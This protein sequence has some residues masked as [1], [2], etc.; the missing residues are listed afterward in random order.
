M[1]KD[2]D[3]VSTD[4]TGEPKTS[5][6]NAN[7]HASEE[8]APVATG[9]PNQTNTNEEKNQNTAILKTKPDILS[10]FDQS[11]VCSGLHSTFNSDSERTNPRQTDLVA[12]DRP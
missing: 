7:N 10:R 5:G 6:R 12:N 4:R 9:N 8:I 2:R 3:V 1:R 11:P